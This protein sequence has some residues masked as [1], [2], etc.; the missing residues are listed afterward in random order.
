[1][2]TR[3]RLKKEELK[4][5]GRLG[6]LIIV[7]LFF[8]GCNHLDEVERENPTPHKESFPG[9]PLDEETV[10]TIQSVLDRATTEPFLENAPVSSD[11]LLM[12]PIP[13][14]VVGIK[15][16]DK[17][18]WFG[19]SGYSNLESK[20]P[21]EVD[22]KFKIASV[23]KSIVATA[24]L[25]LSEETEALSI[26]DTVEEWLPGIVPNGGNIT[27]RNLMMHSSCLNNYTSLDGFNVGMQQNPGQRWAHEVFLAMTFNAGPVCGNIGENFNYSN[28]NYFLLGMILEKVKK[29][30][31]NEVL[32]EYFFGPLEL[33]NT[34]FQTAGDNL[35]GDYASGYFDLDQNFV[36]DEVPY[37]DPSALWAAGATVSDAKD[38]LT[39]VNAAFKTDGVLL[40]SALQEERISTG[41]EGPLNAGGAVLS[42][43]GLK[44]GMGLIQRGEMLGHVGEIFGYSVYGG[45]YVEKQ[46]SIVVLTNKT[47]YVKEQNKEMDVFT[48]IDSIFLKLYPD[49]YTIAPIAQYSN[50]NAH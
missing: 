41:Y 38:L 7:A 3:S 23:T 44:I 47:R 8:I 1:M 19:A 15:I 27:L 14:V 26:D 42:D 13:G 16:P 36:L 6:V 24:I 43:A 22:D 33:R 20:I 21:M 37:V 2:N 28:T 11:N 39:W 18:A 50:T 49:D 45:V 25:K 46:I 32:K 30:T 17:Q 40:S 35:S 12:P 29:T 9:T 5:Y 31:L 34:Y 10:S 4:L 48:I